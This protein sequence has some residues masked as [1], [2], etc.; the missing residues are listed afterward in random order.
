[1]SEVEEGRGAADL[2]AVGSSGRAQSSV[3]LLLCPICGLPATTGAGSTGRRTKAGEL[4]R[5]RKCPKGHTVRTLERVVGLSVDQLVVR[6]P[7]TRSEIAHAIKT[8]AASPKPRR[9][10]RQWK[11]EQFNSAHLAER[12]HRQLFGMLEHDEC[13]AIAESV[14]A[15]LSNQLVGSTAQRLH[16]EQESHPD[17]ASTPRMVGLLKRGQTGHDLWH[18]IVPEQIRDLVLAALWS[19]GDSGPGGGGSARFRAAHVVYALSTHG[20]LSSRPEDWPETKDCKPVI[21]HHVEPL[22]F[23]PDK[24]WR[25]AG[26]FL[27]WLEERHPRLD[28]AIRVPRHARPVEWWR[29]IAAPPVT[30]LH[31]VKR[32]RKL[33]RR[34]V[35]ASYIDPRRDH[36]E[37]VLD[38]ARQADLATEH[39][40]HELEELHKEANNALLAIEHIRN[41]SSK[42]DIEDRAADAAIVPAL[43]GVPYEP[44]LTKKLADAVAGAVAGRDLDADEGTENIVAWVLWS[45]LGQ[46]V[47]LSSQLGAAVADCLRRVDDVAYLRWVIVAKELRVTSIQR[48]A[49][50]LVNYPS[51]RLVFNESYVKSPLPGSG[52]HERV[53]PPA[54]GRSGGSTG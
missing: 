19:I 46:E 24:H 13:V 32:H 34:G 41:D 20:R 3:S 52:P 15:D 38:A 49:A 12:L 22:G 43:A 4:P 30:P 9:R 17:I 37:A 50:G 21:D 47:V 35:T 18:F 44:F 10:Y 11:Y 33:R 31:V 2:P 7:L 23:D 6:I 53:P 39:A 45:M 14:R 16:A 48:E 40:A 1:M 42:S 51:P 29:P 8:D 25:S 5:T 54:D 28:K 36:G 26:D 27:T